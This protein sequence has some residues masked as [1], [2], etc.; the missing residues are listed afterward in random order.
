VAHTAGIV[1]YE[2]QLLLAERLGTL[3]KL[4]GQFTDCEGD[5]LDRLG[6]LSNTGFQITK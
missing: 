5:I 3:G 1:L 2:V 6:K 4:R